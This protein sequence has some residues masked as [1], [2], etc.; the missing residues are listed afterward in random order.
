MASAGTMAAAP[1]RMVVQPNRGPCAASAE[2]R[3]HAAE[4]EGHSSPALQWRLL[5]LRDP[6]AAGGECQTSKAERRVNQVAVEIA[7]GEPQRQQDDQ[8]REDAPCRP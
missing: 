4:R 8:R 5:T 3:L 7:E 6:F 2:R 1:S